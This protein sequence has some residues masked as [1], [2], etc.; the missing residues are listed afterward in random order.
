MQYFL[1]LLITD[2][3][4]IDALHLGSECVMERLDGDGI[5]SRC[6]LWNFDHCRCYSRMFETISTSIWRLLEPAREYIQ[7]SFDG[8]NPSKPIETPF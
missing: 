4:P 1:E 6:L 5:V 7:S 2:V 3:F 8:R